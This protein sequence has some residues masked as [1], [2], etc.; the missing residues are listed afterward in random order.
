MG[1]LY[2]R[3]TQTVPLRVRSPLPLW[4]S[5]ANRPDSPQISLRLTFQD[6]LWIVFPFACGLSI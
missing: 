6:G 1:L 2:V 3:R 5:F 4:D